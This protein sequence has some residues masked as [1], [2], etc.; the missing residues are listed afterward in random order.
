M[1]KRI[2]SAKELNFIRLKL[3]KGEPYEIEEQPMMLYDAVDTPEIE[4]R[5]EATFAKYLLIKYGYEEYTNDDL[6]NK[7]AEIIILQN[8]GTTFG[9]IIQLLIDEYDFTREDAERSC[10]TFM[11]NHPQ[12]FDVHPTI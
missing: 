8:Q 9:E 2:L 3:E 1:S 11:K 5:H 12:E 4:A 10:R 7:I 6:K